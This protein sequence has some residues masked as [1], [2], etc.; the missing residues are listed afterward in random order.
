MTAQHELIELV[1][2]I[3]AENRIFQGLRTIDLLE[4][5]SQRVFGILLGQSSVTTM[6]AQ[7]T[8]RTQVVLLRTTEEFCAGSAGP[9][10]PSGVAHGRTGEDI[11][12]TTL[13]VVLMTEQVVLVGHNAQD[14]Q[15]LQPRLDFAA[16][17]GVAGH[18]RVHTVIGCRCSIELGIL[19]PFLRIAL[20]T[21]ALADNRM[22]EDITDGTDDRTDFSALYLHCPE[23]GGLVNSQRFRI[24]Q[25]LH[26]RLTAIG[27]VSDFRS[28]TARH[29]Y[30]KTS[31]VV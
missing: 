22:R 23:N 26:R 19:A 1:G 30:C 25:T 31:C 7:T 4:H 13:L 16:Q 18:L 29:G 11:D 8:G 5:Q 10:V 14:G 21:V 6:E 9:A 12:A 20:G 3:L 2:L 15:L 27:G 24:K 28:L 17:A